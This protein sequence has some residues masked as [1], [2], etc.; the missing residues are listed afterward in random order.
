MRA[1]IWFL[2]SLAVVVASCGS[3]VTNEATSDTSIVA[4]TV[5]DLAIAKTSFQQTIGSLGA[6]VLNGGVGVSGG[7]I[8]GIS[9]NSD[10][11]TISIWE[12]DE[13]Q[14]GYGAELALMDDWCGTC[15]WGIDN[16]QI[17]DLTGEGN[18][19]I[20]VD[21][22]LNDTESQV[23]SQVLGSWKSL[24]FD[25]IPRGSKVVGTNVVAYHEPC[26]PSCS[27]G[28]A[29]AITYT[30]NGTKFESHAEDDFGNRFTLTIPPTCAVFTPTE[31]EPY[32]L[33]DKSDGIRYLQQVLYESGLLYSTSSNP[34]DGYFGP[35]TEY[36]V[37]VYQYQNLLI[38]DGVVEGQWY[39][40]LIENYNLSLQPTPQ[41]P[42]RTQQQTKVVINQT[43]EAKA[44]AMSSNLKG[45]YYSYRIYNNWSDG[46]T[47][48]ATGGFGYSNQ[49]PSIC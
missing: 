46:T 30:W 35:E 27:D 44:T 43:C 39:R 5:E 21:Y 4:I 15:T 13:N 49:L 38:V 9:A 45:T 24:E 36:S 8:F 19:D 11:G 31:Y 17:V 1:K 16:L 18:D 29:I 6:S 20:F 7:N 25:L 41:S 28:G 12:W 33:C 34:V 47:S 3:A 23:F 22:H 2:T 48:I 40:D 26:L 32:K 37:K 14:F 10:K 42:S